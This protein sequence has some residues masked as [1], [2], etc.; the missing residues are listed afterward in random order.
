M[1]KKRVNAGLR[2]RLIVK[3]FDFAVFHRGRVIEGHCLERVIELGVSHSV[4]EPQ[5]IACVHNGGQRGHDS[6]DPC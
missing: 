1:W 5:K 3:N 2:L 6:H 4:L